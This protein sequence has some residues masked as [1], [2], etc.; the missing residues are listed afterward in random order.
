MQENNSVMN[1]ASY[2][3]PGISWTAPE[4]SRPWQQ[5]PQLTDLSKVALFYIAT[6]SDPEMMDGLLDSI[7]TTV[8]L[9]TIAE[10]MM[11]NG[12]STGV[13]TMDAG[14]LAMPVIIEMLQSLA[15]A[16]D[17][18]FVVYADD[19]D[20]E[21]TVSSRVARLAVQKAM[22]KIEGVDTE[23]APMPIEE[24]KPKGLMAKRK[25]VM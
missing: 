17:T 4:K 11:L 24:E 23:E 10:A 3:P 13:H 21:A 18:K 2:T 9:A 20:K 6:L 7:E 8:P 1:L 15:I 22:K 12:V 5:P 25:E 14:V 16:H 19:Y